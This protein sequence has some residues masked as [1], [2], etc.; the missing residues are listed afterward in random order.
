MD[1]WPILTGDGLKSDS[2]A[3]LPVHTEHYRR[4]SLAKQLF[5]VWAMLRLL[6]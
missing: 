4:V 6:L 2:I 1:R 3:F 5:N